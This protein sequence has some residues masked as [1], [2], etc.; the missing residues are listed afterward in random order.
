MN[1][2]KHKIKSNT[3]LFGDAILLPLDKE[4]VEQRIT[5]L[6]DRINALFKNDMWTKDF[7]A[8]QLNKLLKAEELWSTLLEN[9]C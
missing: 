5:V 8:E 9:H 3:E 4:A 6:R 2:L 7:N 1:Q